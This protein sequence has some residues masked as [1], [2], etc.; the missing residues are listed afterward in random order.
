MQVAIMPPEWATHLVS[1]LGDMDR[2]PRRLAP[3]VDRELR[4]E[5]PDDVYFE[6]AFLD[7]SGRMYADPGN[8]LR[9]D[10]PWYP[11]VSAVLGP[12]YLPDP[13][14]DPPQPPA[15]AVV[16]RLRVQ[17]ATLHQQRRV[18]VATPAGYEKQALPL[19]LVQD[20]IAFY[21]LARLSDVLAALLAAGEAR[22]ARVAFVEP[23][24]RSREYAYHEGYLRFVTNELLAELDRRY[25]MA[26]ELVAAGASLGGLF[27]AF[28]ALSRPDLVRTVVTFSG[29][30]VGH[31][32]ARDFYAGRRS[33]VAESL[34]RGVPEGLRWYAECGTLE[35]LT[36][37][38]RRVIAA[39]EA[40]G[41]PYAYTERNAGHNWTNWRN[42]LAE[43]LRFALKP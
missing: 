43:A 8:A 2:N 32:E 4:L 33:F 26:D 38:N 18:I 39:L 15:P 11:Q 22:P 34:E 35:W 9:A 6:Y 21:R 40:A 23:V 12:D 17:S 24:E 30:F 1:D 37:A 16:D 14:A 25:P 7:E 36:S 5:L 13:L 3:G 29:A 28:L 10:N 41:A 31:P 20:G 42:G 27:S 19:V